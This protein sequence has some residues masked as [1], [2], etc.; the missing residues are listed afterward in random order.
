MVAGGRRGDSGDSV[1]PSLTVSRAYAHV[2][3]YHLLLREAIS[4]GQLLLSE[5]AEETEFPTPF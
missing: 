1:T 3:P 4:N 5:L 2:L